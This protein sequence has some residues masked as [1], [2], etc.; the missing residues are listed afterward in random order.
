MTA[1]TYSEHND[2]IVSYEHSEN[3]KIRYSDP[4]HYDSGLTNYSSAENTT[5]F[6]MSD[7]SI[8]R[9]NDEAMR[10][11]SIHP[12]KKQMKK[13]RKMKTAAGAIGGVIVG[14]LIAGPVG[15]VFGAPIGGYAAN[16]ISKSGERRAQRKFEKHSFQ[17]TADQSMAALNGA[18][19]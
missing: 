7:G 1:T 9:L 13:M 12:S 18:Y 19:V 10:A 4:W 14:T 6:K 8:L 15:L 11:L 5:K 17:K 16:K 3:E 2:Q